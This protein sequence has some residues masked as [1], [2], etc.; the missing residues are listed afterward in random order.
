[1]IIPETYVWE[2]SRFLD[3]GSPE[4]S[5][6][7][8]NPLEETGRPAMSS[9]SRETALLTSLIRLCE[10]GLSVCAHARISLT[11]RDAWPSMSRCSRPLA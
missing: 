8:E 4:G 1:M 10:R 7:Y 2:E 3:L 9:R 6:C 11:T 5:G